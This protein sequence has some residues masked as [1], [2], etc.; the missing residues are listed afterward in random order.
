M[1]VRLALTTSYAE[2]H[3]VDVHRLPIISP[4]KK[5]KNFD[6]WS[7][8]MVIHMQVL[9]QQEEEDAFKEGKGSWEDCSKQGVHGF[10][11]AE[12]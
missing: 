1:G 3:F 12:S 7:A 2:L 4:A 6:L 10:S 5:K 9:T 11:L 8:T